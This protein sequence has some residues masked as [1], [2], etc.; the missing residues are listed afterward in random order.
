M[1]RTAIF[2]ARPRAQ[3]NENQRM[4]RHLRAWLVV[5]VMLLPGALSAQVQ[6]IAD[7]P[8]DLPAQVRVPLAQA[9]VS[10][11][12]R[13]EQIK[14]RVAEQNA[15]CSAVPEGS[16]QEQACRAS[17]AELQTA[18][19]QYAADVRKFNDDVAAAIATPKPQPVKETISATPTTCAQRA[20]AESAYSDLK[21]R[22][23]T[24]QQ[25]IRNFGFEQ[26]ADEIQAWADSG[27]QARKSYQE[28]AHGILVDVVLDNIVRGLK[29][30]VSA[31][32]AISQ[33]SSNLLVNMF[34]AAGLP[35]DDAA[36]QIARNGKTITQE[37]ADILAGRIDKVKDTYDKTEDLKDLTNSQE[38]LELARSVAAVAGWRYPAFTWL[39][40]DLDTV[41]L[42]IYSITYDKA[43]YQVNQLTQLTETQ[44]K[45]L[46]DFTKRLRSDTAQLRDTVEALKSLPPCDSTTMIRK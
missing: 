44:L 15:K 5:A 35:N 27:E 18:I 30:G 22:V 12:Q 2:A 7:I 26:R 46:N 43:K 28:K 17:K 4:A 11:V 10:L 36:M 25:I 33:E 31:A 38:R 41:S 42:A 1:N 39:A 32:P 19:V 6:A 29:A 9:R 45:E 21:Q 23:Q 34:K 16:P 13:K 3:G 20:N 40:K 37:Q 8:D 14:V 24:D